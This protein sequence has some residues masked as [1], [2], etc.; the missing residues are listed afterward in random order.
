MYE[1]YVKKLQRKG[2]PQKERIYKAHY[3]RF[4]YLKRWAIMG[5]H[6]VQQTD[7]NIYLILWDTSF[8]RD[9]GF[10]QEIFANHEPSQFPHTRSKIVQLPWPVLA[11]RWHL[12]HPGIYHFFASPSGPSQVKRLSKTI[13]ASLESCKSGG[14]T[15]LQRPLSDPRQSRFRHI[16]N[17]S[18]DAFIKMRATNRLSTSVFLAKH[19]SLTRLVLRMWAN[20]VCSSFLPR[21]ALFQHV[22]TKPPQIQAARSKSS[23]SCRMRTR[24]RITMDDT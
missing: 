23:W 7:A 16:Q 9:G 11:I 1:A 6:P 13:L 5:S 18:L 21:P 12:F 22:S 2:C 10:N 24:W 19:V 14:M 15:D 8:Q 20:A 4:R 17:C 3:L